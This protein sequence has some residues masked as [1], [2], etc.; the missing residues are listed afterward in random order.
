MIELIQRYQIPSVWLNAKLESDCVYPDDFE[1][2]GQACKYLLQMGHRRIAY[3]DYMSSGHYSTADRRNGYLR[4]M[5]SARLKPQIFSNARERPQTEWLDLSCEWL[6][7]PNARL[8]S[9][10]T[11]PTA[12]C[13]SFARL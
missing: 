13:P 5:R 11:K 2:A 8:P 3:V 9:S 12:R 1:A 10:P 6:R 7:A 4:A